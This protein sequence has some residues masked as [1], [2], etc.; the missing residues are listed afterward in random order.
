MWQL[1]VSLAVSLAVATAAYLLGLS[2]GRREGQLGI[3]MFKEGFERRNAMAN[4]L[5]ERD[6]SMDPSPLKEP[7][8]LDL[9]EPMT[10]ETPEI[11]S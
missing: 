6:L 7:R 5:L 1:P 11:E 4:S 3:A 8:E 2:Q 9:L 10:F